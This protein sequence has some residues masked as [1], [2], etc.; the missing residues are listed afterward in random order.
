MVDTQPEHAP[1]FLKEVWILF[2]VGA[3]VLAL[4]FVVRSRIAGVRGFQ[5]DDYMSIVVFLCYLVDAVTVTYT[6]YYGTNVDFTIERLETMSDAQLH[7][8]KL[9]SQLQL[10][11]W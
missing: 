10:L 5:G 3:A 6:Y 8:I 9:G 7:Q 4:R 2:G 1:S 11:A